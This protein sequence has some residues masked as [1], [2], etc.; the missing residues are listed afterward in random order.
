MRWTQT[1]IPTLKEVPSD[2][3]TPSHRLRARAGLIRKLT[4]GAYT[5]LPLGG[6]ALRK[7]EPV[8]AAIGLAFVVYSVGFDISV[9]TSGAMAPTLQGSAF[10]D[11]DV[12]LTE[13]LSYWFRGPRR[14][15]VLTF[16]NSE[17]ILNH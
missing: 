4:A 10:G 1:L 12:V 16:R 8:F 3:E 5:Y 6:R 11:G 13:K 7:A 9:V 17:G 2:A 15:E 14:W